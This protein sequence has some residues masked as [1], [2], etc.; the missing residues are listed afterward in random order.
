MTAPGGWNGIVEAGGLSLAL[1]G[2]S[3]VFVALICISLYITALPRVLALWDSLRPA[4]APR[5]AS[6]APQP[7]RVQVAQKNAA[8]EAEAAAALLAVAILRHDPD[9]AGL[10]G[11]TTTK[12]TPEN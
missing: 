10:L 11:M 9:A 3:V 12:S 5:H 8:P 6:P 1:A 2:M 7:P 4:S